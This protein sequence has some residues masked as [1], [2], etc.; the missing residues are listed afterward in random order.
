MQKIKLMAPFGN[1]GLLQGVLENGC[2]SIFDASSEA[3]KS[4]SGIS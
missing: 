3:K 4:L 2:D 1:F